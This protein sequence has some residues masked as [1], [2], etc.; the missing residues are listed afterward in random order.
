M[1]LLFTKEIEGNNPFI[2]RSLINEM[3]DIIKNWNLLE[4]NE[5]YEFRLVL[6]EL[7]ANGIFHG[8]KGY[9]EKKVRVAIEEKN[10]ITLMITIKD[11]GKGFD[12]S[13][14][15]NEEQNSINMTESGRGLILV[16]AFCNNIQFNE[17]GNQ[18][19]ITKSICNK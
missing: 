16:N 2:V 11:D 6:N 4:D 3:M 19:R 8:N 14:I 9:A 17:N 10:P 13:K 15:C 7:I 5:D 1:K 18:I 12:Y